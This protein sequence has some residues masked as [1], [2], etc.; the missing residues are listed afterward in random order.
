MKKLNLGFQKSEID[1]LWDIMEYDKKV[2]V[3]KVH[4]ILPRRIGQVTITSQVDRREFIRIL[5]LN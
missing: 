1:R 3:G 2:R 5:N 4:F